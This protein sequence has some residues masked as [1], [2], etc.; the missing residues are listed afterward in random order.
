MAEDTPFSHKKMRPSPSLALCAAA[1]AVLVTCAM[2]RPPFPSLTG[3]RA[4]GRPYD[5]VESFWLLYAAQHTHPACR[6]LHRVGTSHIAAVAWATGGVA[7]VIRVALALSATVATMLPLA[8]VLAGCATGA[9]EFVLLVATFL[10]FARVF[11]A[12]RPRTM[13]AMIVPAYAVAWVS[14]FAI[15]RNRPATFSH[16]VY[17][18]CGDLRMFFAFDVAEISHQASTSMR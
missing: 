18:L 17:S 4:K 13:L 12:G 5:T 3:V 6:A 16:P 2:V 7:R 10:G 1:T 8:D 15:E 14:H 9:P 11:D